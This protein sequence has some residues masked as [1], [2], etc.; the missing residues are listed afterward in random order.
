MYIPIKKRLTVSGIAIIAFVLIL[1]ISSILIIKKVN[2][3]DNMIINSKNNALVLEMRLVEH[4]IW[5]NDL[6]KSITT[7]TEFTSEVN[8][9]LCSFGQWLYKYRETEEYNSLP[10][11]HRAIFD[12]IEKTHK[13]LHEAASDIKQTKDLKKSLDILNTITYS[14]LYELRTLFNFLNNENEKNTKKITEEVSGQI[15]F[16]NLLIYSIILI[17][18]VLIIL[19]I[20]S[21]RK[22][23]TSSVS[24]IED[25]IYK[26]SQGNLDFSVNLKAVNCSED[27]KCENH[28]CSLFEKENT[29]CFLEVGSYAPL[30]KGETTCP[31]ILEG[32]Y[33]TCD[34]CSIMKKMVSDELA[35]QIILL[36]NFK[37]K[38]KKIISKVKDMIHNLATSTEQMSSSII[39]LSDN[40]QSQAASAEEITATVEEISAS[41]VSI[42]QNT[43]TQYN[44]VSSLSE[45]IEN[46]SIIIEELGLKTKDSQ[47]LS[48]TISTQAKAG[49]ESLNSMNVSMSTIHKS[50]NEMIDI[51][52]IIND[53][54]D[55]INLLSL[56]AAIEAARAGEAGRGFAVVADEISKLADQTALSLNNIDSLIK[57]NE[58]EILK[59][60][61]IV[62]DTIDRIAGIIE[63]ITGII[64]MTDAIYKNMQNQISIN[65]IVN[66]EAEKTLLIADEIK[67]SS[68]EQG[69]AFEEIVKSISNINE[70][71]QTN[72]SSSEEIAG[73]SENLTKMAETVRKEIEFF[74]VGSK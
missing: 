49:D 74:N 30:I 50:S 56:N 63:S 46:L 11:S 36:E 28:D 13:I 31:S 72:A 18:A 8:P 10:S 66:K 27:T 16:I 12:R 43:D 44:S 20:L 17:T 21:L 29:S 39:N 6:V 4:L 54:S 67:I 38:I 57:T 70:L 24:T 2:E 53:I 65:N 35:F 1:G 62:K 51:I 58:K 7:G 61:N 37:E 40:I 68:Q 55:K 71:T 52:E 73:V 14:N 23:I 25:T 47:T 45:K 19:I 41:A 42:A 3:A 9:E 15:A 48:E 32:K 33:K 64:E 26:L 60:V 69:K 22:K 34:E 59:G 5:S